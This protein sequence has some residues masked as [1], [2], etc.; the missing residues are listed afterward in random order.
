MRMPES[1]P[2]HQGARCPGHHVPHARPAPARCAPAPWRAFRAWLRARRG[3]IALPG[4]RAD[5]P[6]LLG[7]C[8]APSTHT[9]TPQWSSPLTAT[10]TA[11]LRTASRPALARRA[12][13][14]ARPSPS[15][16]SSW[17]PGRRTARWSSPGPL[18]ASRPRSPTRQPTT[19]ATA[20]WRPTTSHL[21][22]AHACLRRRPVL[23]VI[24]GCGCDAPVRMART[25][26]ASHQR[27]VSQGMCRTA[28][29]AALIC[30]RH[31]QGVLQDAVLG[32][33]RA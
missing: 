29:C 25:H 22:G 15:S 13:R 7:D 17:C 28:G 20:T 18:T 24:P 4:I 33:H 12:G 31:E 8:R 5:R 9:R 14:P 23:A 10:G 19:I 3:A 11:A 1:S 6:A 16:C 30:S 32:C 26:A 21:H 27:A 2:V